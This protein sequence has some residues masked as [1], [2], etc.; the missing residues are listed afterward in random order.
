MAGV[1]RQ[2]ALKPSHDIFT[3]CKLFFLLHRS[4]IRLL[5]PHRRRRFATHTLQFIHTFS[6]A[7]RKDGL[8]QSYIRHHYCTVI[9][10]RLDTRDRRFSLT[11]SCNGQV[12]PF[13]CV[14]S[15]APHLDTHFKVEC[16]SQHAGF[17][18]AVLS[19]I[20]SLW[21]VSFFYV[22]FV[23]GLPFFSGLL[24]KQSALDTD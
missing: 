4:N 14:T 8:F 6:I 1:G 2:Q 20:C 18:L 19:V 12:K 11:P 9:T 24:Q 5:V 3:H 23:M 13:Q 15:K 21:L 10:A 22:A 7:D 17:R 16:L